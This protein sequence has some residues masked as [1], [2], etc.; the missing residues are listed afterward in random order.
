MRLILFATIVAHAAAARHS[1]PDEEIA[2]LS[3]LYSSFGKHNQ[4]LKVWKNWLIGDPCNCTK[5]DVHYPDEEESLIDYC[6][7]DVEGHAMQ[8]WEGL[9][10][11]KNN[12]ADTWT[13]NK[14]KFGSL[15]LN[16]TIPSQVGSLSS[17]YT[18]Q[19]KDNQFTGQIPTELGKMSMVTARV[20]FWSNRL[21][22]TIP[23]E[24]GNW[25]LLGRKIQINPENAVVG[26]PGN[27][28]TGTIPTQLGK[29]T[30]FSDQLAFSSAGLTGPLPTELGRLSLMD[31][32]FM[33]NKN[34]LSGTIPTEF[35]LWTGMTSN[36]L[37][38]KNNLEGP[39]PTEFG[40]MSLINQYWMLQKND[41]SGSIPT[42]LGL[43]TALTD[44]LRLEDNDLSGSIPSEFGLLNSDM[45]DLDLTNND[46][47][48]D[49]PNATLFQS[50]GNANI[51]I[52]TGNTLE[53]ECTTP[54]PTV[55]PIPSR[56]PTPV[57]STPVPSSTPSQAPSS[58]PIALPTAVPS[59]IPT[60][61]PTGLP[62]AVPAPLPSTAVPTSVPST[63]VPTEG[64]GAPTSACSDRDDWHRKGFAWKKCDWVSEYPQNRCN[65]E[66]EDGVYSYVACASTCAT[67]GPW[68]ID[69]NIVTSGCAPSMMPTVYNESCT[70]D[71]TW[72]L[73]NRINKGCDW[74][75]MY[76]NSRCT[77]M[78]DDGRYAFEG[79]EK[80]CG[81]CHC[82]DSESWRIKNKA[83]RGCGWVAKFPKNRCRR[84]GEGDTDVDTDGYT[85]CPRT[86]LSC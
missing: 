21:G 77:K 8:W 56:E 39:L 31:T 17:V 10:C 29:L 53:V 51:N 76:S 1:T 84:I 7:G 64:T 9:E 73:N 65:R 41:F 86:C 46:L 50:S 71:D 28:L 24:L 57:P 44:G 45:T 83:N 12:T 74:V 36:F 5:Y 78:G 2:A 85:S 13:V 42:E 79:C 15:G 59:S 34:Q 4:A 30:S 43:L 81:T 27:I 60:S 67:H 19:F 62:T 11:A 6:D 22:S 40:A 54:A 25:N 16:G 48:G 33:V 38:R 61:P 18:F 32:D 49:I 70:N 47:C 68:T 63:A 55:S 69:G 80:T 72:Y 66:G 82:S 58:I 75:K 20:G 52:T 23:S 14:I 35:G 37:L 3:Q 26:F